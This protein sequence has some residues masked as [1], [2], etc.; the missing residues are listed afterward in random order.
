MRVGEPG[1][2]TVSTFPKSNDNINANTNT[3]QSTIKGLKIC[4]LNVLV[5]KGDTLNHL[6]TIVLYQRKLKQNNNGNTPNR[7][8]EKIHFVTA[9]LDIFGFSFK[10]KRTFNISNLKSKLISLCQ[11]FVNKGNF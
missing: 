5:D 10:Q 2:L 3:R 6:F 11:I 8:L 7:K 4:E 1:L 9:L